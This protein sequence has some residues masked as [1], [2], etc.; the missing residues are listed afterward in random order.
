M[1]L[2]NRHKSFKTDD[3]LRSEVDFWHLFITIVLFFIMIAFP[4]KALKL[5]FDYANSFE[6]SMIISG[7][8]VSASSNNRP[9]VFDSYMLTV[10]LLP[11]NFPAVSTGTLSN[12]KQKGRD[13]KIKVSSRYYDSVKRGDQ[14]NIEYAERGGKLY[15]RHADNYMPNWLYYFFS[16]LSLLLLMNI[17]GRKN[18]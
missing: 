8:E 1:F 10:K 5:S 9:S 17:R 2:H 6:R 15:A 3:E 11:E 7:K 4:I 13:K 18:P 16:F 12:A 14:I